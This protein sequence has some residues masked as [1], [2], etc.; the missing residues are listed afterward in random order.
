MLTDDERLDTVRR[1]ANVRRW[2]RNGDILV[3]TERLE[4]ML[5]ATLTPAPTVG[6]NVSHDTDPTSACPE[7]VARRKA[8]ATRQKR[9]ADRKR[10]QKAA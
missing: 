1:I 9:H 7:C 5:A 3:L 10:A 6:P 8:N 2:T 4:R